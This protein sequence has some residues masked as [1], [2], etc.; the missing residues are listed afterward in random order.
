MVE[1][2]GQHAHGAGKKLLSTKL[3]LWIVGIV[4]ALVLIVFIASFFI[5]EP[6]RRATEKKMNQSLKGYSVRLPKLHFSLIGLSITLK[7]LTVS[8]QAHPEPP[9]AE[10]PYLRAS[11]H[12]REILSGKLVGEMRLDD[13]KIHINLT[14]LKSEAKS[15]VPMKEKG[16]QQAVE[17]IYPLKINHLKINDASITY[18]DEDAKR[19]LVLSNLDLEANNIR[20]IHLP[21]KV[22]PSSFHLETDIFKTGHGTVD[23]KANFLAEPTPAVKA[24][25]KLEKVPIDYFQP[26]LARY[27]MSVQG[28]ALSGNGDIEYGRKVQTARLKKLVISGV[29][30][31]YFHSEK[32]AAVEKRRAEKVKAAAKEVSNKPNLV[33]SIE[34]FDLV[35]SNLGMMYN[36]GGKKFRIFVAD[37]DFSLSNFSN[38]F[39]R[40][41]AKAKLSG[42]F[43]GSGMTSASGD[44]RPEKNGPDFD[45]YLKITNT[46]LTSLNDLLRS[47]GDFDVT[48]GT[49][50]LVTELH[51]KNERVD[52]YIKPFFRDMKVYDRRQDKNKGFFKQ[53]KEILIGGIAK[54]LENKQRDQVATKADISGPLKNPQTSTWQIVVQLVRNAFFKAI[55]PTFER[56]VTA[57][58]KK[59]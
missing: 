16:W 7:G 31:T 23:G 32:T 46:Q 53:V 18:I 50:S 57:L 55:V 48:A 10:F 26:V 27:N 22:Y 39:S 43:M 30:M 15:K 28:G 1:E 24:D 5:D 3:L 42:K 19:P 11:V 51:V 25:L 13:P 52:G 35:R 17:A 9:V 34:Q 12:W 29:T 54:I 44:F 2:S 59:R 4:V 33:L 21:D 6:L 38:Q 40:G 41:A 14:Q 47:Y 37:T 49:F 8:Q 45:L 58:G 36:A 56:D 20:N